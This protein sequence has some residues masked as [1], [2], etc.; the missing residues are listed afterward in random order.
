[1]KLVDKGRSLLDWV[2]RFLFFWACLILI[3]MVLGVN[4]DVGMRYFLGHH[5]EWMFEVTEYSLVFLTF[6]G[7]AWVLRQEGH[8]KM[9][10]LLNR[11]NPTAQALVNTITSIIC[12]I[13]CLLLTWYGAVVT[14]DCFQLNYRAATLIGPPL[15]PMLGIIPV[16]SFL[17]AI[18]FLR[19][20]YGFMGDW[21]G[22]SNKE[23]KK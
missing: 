18:Q 2:M 4:T 17:L 20:S 3:F 15:W 6:L 8:V 1:M 23:R 12:A 10:L 14:R 5:I 13:V 22:L 21:R 9:D 7:M 19:R 16:G 11:L